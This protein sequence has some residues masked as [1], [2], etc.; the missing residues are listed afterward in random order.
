[1]CNECLPE[2]KNSHNGWE[3]ERDSGILCN[4]QERSEKRKMKTKLS[5][6]NVQ[7]ERYMLDIYVL[8]YFE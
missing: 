1:M 2:R 6:R 7:A 4:E 8:D 3:G 5:I